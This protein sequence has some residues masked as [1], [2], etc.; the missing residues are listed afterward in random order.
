MTPERLEGLRL[1]ILGDKTDISLDDTLNQLDSMASKRLIFIIGNIK[2]GLGIA[3]SSPV[4]VPEDLMWI[5]DEV[6]IRRFNRLGSEGYQSQSVEG[7]S[8]SFAT[9][10]FQDYIALIKDYYAPVQPTG[11]S[12]GQVV[13]I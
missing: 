10:D 5:L 7:H 8:V 11:G 9:D 13:L 12:M 3:S 1:L 6:V 4:P 2:K